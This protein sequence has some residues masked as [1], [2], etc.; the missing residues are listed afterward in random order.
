MTLG[1]KNA[2]VV[3]FATEAQIVAVSKTPWLVGILIRVVVGSGTLVYIL[4]CTGD[5][6]DEE[7]PLIKEQHTQG[8]SR[9]RWKC[10]NILKF[11]R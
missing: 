10:V 6:G 4:H 2:W 5:S 1:T 9:V 7:L 11:N 8:L 3:L